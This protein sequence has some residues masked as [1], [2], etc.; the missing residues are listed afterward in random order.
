[1]IQLIGYTAAI[2]TASTM[3]PQIIKSLST[4]RVN[5][6]SLAMT[7][8]YATNAALWVTY[9]FLIGAT[10]VVIADGLA[11]LLGTTQ[12]IIKLKYDCNY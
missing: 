10:P 6:I 2:L 11:F 8:M 4:R 12:L 3:M 1:M 7:L 5:D 9:G